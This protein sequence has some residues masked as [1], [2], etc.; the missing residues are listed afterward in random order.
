MYHPA[1]VVLWQGVLKAAAEPSGIVR[2]AHRRLRCRSHSTDLLESGSCCCLRVG[3]LGG[4]GGHRGVVSALVHRRRWAFCELRRIILRPKSYKTSI[5]NDKSLTV[6]SSRPR[7]PCPGRDA[8]FT[9][10]HPSSPRA[11]LRHVKSNYRLLSQ[12]SITPVT[13]CR[14]GQKYSH[15]FSLHNPYISTMYSVILQNLSSPAITYRY[16]LALSHAST[17]SASLFNHPSLA[18]IAS[19]LCARLWSNPLVLRSL[20]N[21]S[22]S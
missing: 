19:K 9:W 2:V 20:K 10:R 7:M 6:C 14:C 5:T 22:I 21:A 8:R 16:L 13:S 4:H 17:S 12:P 11:D 3:Q 18:L 1:V 15:A